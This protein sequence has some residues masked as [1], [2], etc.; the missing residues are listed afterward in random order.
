MELN[1]GMPGAMKNLVLALTVCGCLT[2]CFAQKTDTLITGN[3]VPG[4]WAWGVPSA[5]IL[6]GS[7]IMFDK[8]EDEYFLNK[9][10]VREERNEHFPNFSTHIDNYLQYGPAITVAVLDLCHVPGRHDVPNQ[11]ALLVKAE[12]L[13]LGTT[14]VLK[15]AV[16]EPRPD[17]GAKNSFPSG[18]TTEAFATATFLSLEYGDRSIWIPVGAYATATTVGALRLL[19]NRHWISDVLVGAGIGMLSTEL[20]FRTHQNK[21]GSHGTTSL[22]I[23]PFTAY[24]A[25]GVS[26]RYIL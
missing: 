5:L 18:H 22:R 6:T 16:G 23:D 12:V 1:G 19:N 25:Q 2:R 21:W 8:D 4:K 20:V 9:Y 10:E 14:Y 17:S 7:A 13:A 11:A 3:R 15:N 24:G 26:I